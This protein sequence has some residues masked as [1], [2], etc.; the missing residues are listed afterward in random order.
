MKGYSR[1]G[2]ASPHHAIDLPKMEFL[3]LGN[4]ALM[5]GRKR[6]NTLVMKGSYARAE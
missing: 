5:F 2:E 4:N 1:V 6:M 3:R